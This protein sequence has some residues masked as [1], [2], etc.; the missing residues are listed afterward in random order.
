MKEEALKL[1]DELED[2]MTSL[3]WKTH[4][5]SAMIRRLVEELD[6]QSEPIAWMDKYGN[7]CTDIQKKMYQGNITAQYNYDKN[8]IPLYTS[9]QTKPL[10]DDEIDNL[11]VKV[12][13]TDRNQIIARFARAIEERHGVK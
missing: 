10:S 9:P 5:A 12:C 6:K 4:Q 7:V 11:Y 13:V 3:G 1:A 2:Y 8:T